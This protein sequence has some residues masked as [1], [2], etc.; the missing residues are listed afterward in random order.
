MPRKV[1]IRVRHDDST[2]WAQVNPV[3]AYGE[4]GAESDTGVIKVGDGVTPWSDLP[5][6]L[7][8]VVLNPGDPVP[9]NTPVGA[10]IFRRAA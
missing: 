5:H 7:P 8:V 3:L 4:L 1:L 10:L 6:S 9:A 2:Q